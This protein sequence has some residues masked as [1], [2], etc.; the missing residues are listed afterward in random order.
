LLDLALYGLLGVKDYLLKGRNFW[1]INIPQNC[2]W[3]W[4][5]ILKLRGI[6]KRILKFEVGNGENIFLWFDFW[7]QDGILIEV[8]GHKAV[9]DAQCNLKAKLSYV[10]LNG[11]WYGRPARSDALMEIQSRLHEVS[12]GPYDT[13]VWTISKNGSYVSSET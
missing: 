10:I 11:D 12:F 3:S 6:A 8:F 13:S 4:R 5:N 2:S 7:H 9:Y 1:N